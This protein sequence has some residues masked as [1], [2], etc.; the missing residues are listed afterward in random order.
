KS[1]DYNKVNYTEKVC[2]VIGSEN[3]GVSQELINISDQSI[4]LPMF[5]I[6]TSINVAT[7]TSVA[8]YH[9][10]NKIKK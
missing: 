4:H 7:A 1:I 2:V 9:I 5:G 10:F 3:Y 8:L 6:N